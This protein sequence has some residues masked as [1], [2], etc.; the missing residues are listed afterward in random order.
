MKIWKGK[1]KMIL[2]VLTGALFDNGPKAYEF[3]LG[4][5]KDFVKEFIKNALLL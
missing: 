5:R 2:P 1:Y 3:F 4:K